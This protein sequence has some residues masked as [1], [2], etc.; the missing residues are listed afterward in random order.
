M[1]TTIIFIGLVIGLI[2]IPFLT[3]TTLSKTEKVVA[4]ILSVSTILFLIFVTFELN[5]YHLKGLYSYSIISWIFIISTVLFIILFKNIKIK[6]LTGFLLSPFIILCILTLIVG[7]VI[8]VKKIDEKN[9]IA[10]T[11]GGFISCGEI[12]KITETRL[13]IFDKEVF[14]VDN[15]CLTGITKIEIIKLDDIHAEFLIYHNGKNDSENPYKFHVERK[16][17]W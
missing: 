4:R 12:I 5:G 13:G 3:K 9:K 7:Q 10:I 17:V 16:N 8:Y 11:T 2:C 1:T 14:Q 6:I 15:L